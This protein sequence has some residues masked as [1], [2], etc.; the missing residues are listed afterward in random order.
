MI[1]IQCHGLT[2]L[3]AVNYELKVTRLSNLRS[4]QT[5]V[6][7]PLVLYI[8]VKRC[9]FSALCICGLHQ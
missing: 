5:F 7:M 6:K 1:N 8:D 4:I 9:S 3:L 2:T